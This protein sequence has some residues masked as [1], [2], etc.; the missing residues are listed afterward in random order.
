MSKLA[1]K[2]G[3]DGPDERR[4]LAALERLDTLARDP[5]LTTNAAKERLAHALEEHE[6]GTRHGDEED[7]QAE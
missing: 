6:H 3:R 7:H 1:A 4:V 2:L 5:R